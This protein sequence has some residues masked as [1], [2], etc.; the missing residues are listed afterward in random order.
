M[1]E[2][3]SKYYPVVYEISSKNDIFDFD[4]K[5]SFSKD[6]DYP[7]FS[8]GFQHFIHQSKTKMEIT[9]EF[10]GKK[11]VYYIISQF[12]RYIDDYDSDIN[13]ISKVYFDLDPK[14]NILSRAFYKLWELFFMFDII[15]LKT[16]DF[17]SAHLAEGPGSFIQAT[18]FYR[19]K[20]SKKSKNDKYYAVTLHSEGFQKHIPKL[21]ESFIDY[22]K[23]EKPARFMMHKTFNT[24]EAGTS[25]R[26]DN[27]DLTN[28]KTIK[29][30][31]GNFDKK[32]ANLVT[33]DG[34]FDWANENIQEQEAFKL[35]LAQII[36]AVKIQEVGGSFVCK[37]YETFTQVSSKFISILNSFYKNVYIIKP[38]MSRASNSEKYI[39]CLKFINHK[40]HNKRI[41][42]LD[43]I[44][45]AMNNN[46]SNLVN[47][48][49]DFKITNEFKSHLIRANVDIENKQ[50][51]DIN[52]MITFINKQNFRGEE[53]VQRRQMQIDATKY[54]LDT[55]FPDGK[56]FDNKKNNIVNQTNDLISDNNNDA[57]NLLKKLEF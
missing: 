25:N 26:K 44:L 30:F 23:K 11:K 34:G 31:G 54:W 53:Y 40:D 28:P 56:D 12:E 55:F 33:A 45:A 1:S 5:P 6:I 39:V 46:K 36:T 21:E 42:K 49:P 13:N 51:V 57:E 47:I 38:L 15:D 7:K 50:F 10:E 20:F 3:N 32:K 48:F 9:K 16:E 35:I 18:M 19:D 17:V 2:E 29:I 22:Y 14:P 4:E 43:N 37:M 24:Q 27:G 8:F 52:R 41:S